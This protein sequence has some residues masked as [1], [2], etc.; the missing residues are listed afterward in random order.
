MRKSAITRKNKNRF[1]TFRRVGIP[2]TLSMLW[3]GCVTHVQPNWATLVLTDSSH[4]NDVTLI[5]KKLQAQKINCM[6]GNGEMGMA[7][8]FVDSK[9]FM[10]A[11]TIATNVISRNNLSVAIYTNINEDGFEVWTNGKK[12][13]P[14]PD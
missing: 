3:V 7:L 2:L 12:G 8:I 9:D 1:A 14:Q 11:T 10:R 6:G 13:S 4:M 5:Q